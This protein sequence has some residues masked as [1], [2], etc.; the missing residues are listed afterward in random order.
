WHPPAAWLVE[1]EASASLAPQPSGFLDIRQQFAAGAELR[2]VA[3][4]AQSMGGRARALERH[5]RLF[6]AAAGDALVLAWQ[7]SGGDELIRHKPRKGN[8]GAPDRF[9]SHQ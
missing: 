3:R 2:C 6:R 1:A 5:A 8:A 4:P 7:F 9:R